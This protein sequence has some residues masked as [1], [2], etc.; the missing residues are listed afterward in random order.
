MRNERVA[1]AREFKQQKN[2]CGTLWR[3]RRQLLSWPLLRA[4]VNRDV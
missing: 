1:A 3:Q 4:L 2:I